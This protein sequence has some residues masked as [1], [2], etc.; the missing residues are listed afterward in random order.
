[1]QKNDDDIALLKTDFGNAAK[2][3][4]FAGQ[5]L[6]SDGAKPYL[7]AFI[8]KSLS[9]ILNNAI[10]NQLK[11]SYGRGA[12]MADKDDYKYTVTCDDTKAMCKNG[13]YASMNDASKSMNFYSAWWDVTGMPAAGKSQLWSTKHI[14]DNAREIILKSRISKTS[15]SVG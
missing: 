15:G 11:E 9:D 4:E 7:T 3:A 2:M 14:P 12:I 5:N 8:A 6:A 13:Y 10:I 1:M